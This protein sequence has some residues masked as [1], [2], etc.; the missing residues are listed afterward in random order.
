MGIKVM[1]GQKPMIFHKTVK[2]LIHH[3]IQRFVS[4]AVVVITSQ[5]LEFI[6]S[7]DRFL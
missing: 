5:R 2:N 4:G 3:R 1:F 6:V 7:K